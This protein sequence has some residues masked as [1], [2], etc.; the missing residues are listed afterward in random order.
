MSKSDVNSAIFMEDEPA[1]VARKLKKAYCPPKIVKDNPC[2]DYVK[3]IIFPK[4]NEFRIP[5]SEKPDELETFNSYFE[6][7]EAFVKG[8]VHPKDLK[9]GLTTGLNEMMEPVRV[10][11]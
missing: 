5:S 7:E 6:F 3:H 9:T 8:S 2:L 11:F 4:F 1:D 10:H